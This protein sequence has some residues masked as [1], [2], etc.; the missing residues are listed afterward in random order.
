MKICD[1]VYPNTTHTSDI[2]R[3]GLCV[4]WSGL[5]H[6][7]LS[8]GFVKS[9]QAECHLVGRERFY[10]KDAS[11]SIPHSRLPQVLTLRIHNHGMLETSHRFIDGRP[12][13]LYSHIERACERWKRM[14]PKK[15]IWAEKA[16]FQ[17]KIQLQRAMEKGPK[18]A[19]LGKKGRLRNENKAR[20]G[21]E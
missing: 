10:L 7:S 16:A 5:R 21:N 2:P 15:Q 13:S 14:A 4:P 3:R 9:L 20:D 17:S 19:N 1:V 12:D 18:K 8:C 11:P 6:N